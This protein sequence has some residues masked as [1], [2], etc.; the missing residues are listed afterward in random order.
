MANRFVS[1]FAILSTLPS[2]R[3]L[4][5]CQV[6]ELLLIF[7]TLLIAVFEVKHDAKP[8]ATA[9]D[10]ALSTSTPSPP[11]VFLPKTTWEITKVSQYTFSNLLVKEMTVICLFR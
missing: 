2:Q 5:A 9:P 8:T 6:I 4:L 10:S 11:Q 3:T 1:I 7:G